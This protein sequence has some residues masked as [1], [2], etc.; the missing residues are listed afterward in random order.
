MT[1]QTALSGL[2]TLTS[3]P[4][5][6][7]PAYVV[8]GVL[9]RFFVVLVVLFLSGFVAFMIVGNVEADG[10][11]TNPIARA[12]WYPFYLCIAVA[13]A[14][15]FQNFL[16]ALQGHWPFYAL[17][18]LTAAGVSWSVLPEVTNRRVIALV[19][20]VLVGIYLAMRGDWLQT[21]RLLAFGWLALAV[22]HLLT[23]LLQPGTGV[24]H[25]IHAGAWKGWAL[26]KNQLGGE[27]S[28]ANLL[29]AALLYWH[30]PLRAVWAFAFVLSLGLVLGSQ[31][32]TALITLLVP[33]AL[34]LLFLIAQ[35]SIP[36]ALATIYVGAVGA[37]A[38][39]L[40]LIFLPEQIVGL[41]GKDLTLTGRT[42]IW[43]HS[44]EAIMERPWTG[45]GLGAYWTDL[46]GPAYTIRQALEWTVP[47]AHNAWIDI[48]LAIGLPGL[49]GLV[50][51][52]LIAIARL[53]TRA[54][55]EKDP[56]P[57]LFLLQ[58]LIFSFSESVLWLQNSY[59][60]MW[61]VALLAYAFKPAR[62]RR[63]QPSSR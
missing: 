18:V 20:T 29:F 36:C 57:L 25:G 12:A 1:D 21:I 59:V 62:L 13:A 39:L 54:V 24:D 15:R 5:G 30:R 11:A 45:Y 52:T 28:R 44:V 16:A 56:W 31:S 17:I 43:A 60:S 23:V 4:S 34:F 41:V 35:R 3:R 50:T 63:R 40:G 26:E 14:L 27:M 9:E 47:S 32:K 22:L 38:L 37:G 58:I 33:N 61:F 48:A 55:T 7:A 53:A 49:A 42:D 8:A 19:F 51:M 2:E 46:E 6:P 10:D